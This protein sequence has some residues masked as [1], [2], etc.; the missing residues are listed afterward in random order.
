MVVLV[1][2]FVEVETVGHFLLAPTTP[3]PAL[4]LPVSPTLGFTEELK[5][6]WSHCFGSVEDTECD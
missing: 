2:V 4:L 3:S 6:D 5:S 1:A